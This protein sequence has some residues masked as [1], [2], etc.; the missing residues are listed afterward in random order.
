MKNITLSIPE[1]LIKLGREYAAKQGTTLNALIRMLL[2]ST[3]M[4]EQ[5]SSAKAI[6]TEMKNLK[7]PVKKINWNREDLYEK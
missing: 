4:P 7:S 3:V 1:E 6:I 2:K 5:Q